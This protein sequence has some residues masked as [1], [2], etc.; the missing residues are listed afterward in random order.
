MSVYPFWAIDAGK[1]PDA[2]ST[3][4]DALAN[5]R[6]LKAKYGTDVMVV[7][8]GV[9]A[10]VPEE[11]YLFIKDLINQTYSTTDDACLGVFYWAPEC[12]A[13]SPYKLGAFSNDRPTKIMDAFKEAAAELLK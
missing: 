6:H 4:R 11:G 9:A 13:E 5:I 1:E 2:E 10:G 3:L 7:E 12:N 8:T